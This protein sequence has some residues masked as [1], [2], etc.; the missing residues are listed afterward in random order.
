[1]K[2]VDLR[3]SGKTAIFKEEVR[4]IVFVCFVQNIIMIIVM[5]KPS[6]YDFKSDSYGNFAVIKKIKKTKFDE[7]YF[8]IS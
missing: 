6:L 1:M 7:R 5:Q 3:I 2:E 4:G 8:L